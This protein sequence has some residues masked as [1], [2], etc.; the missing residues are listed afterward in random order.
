MHEIIHDALRLPNAALPHH[1]TAELARRWPD[2]VV[3]ESGDSD[4]DVEPFAQAGLCELVPSSETCLQRPLIWAGPDDGL[5]D[6]IDVGAFDI[7]WSGHAMPALKLTWPDG[8]CQASRWWLVAPDP[9]VGRSFFDAVARWNTEV[10]GEVLVFHAGHWFKDEGFFKAVRSA[11]FDDVV[12]APGLA[13]TVRLDFEQFFASSDMYARYRV[14]WKRGALF[15]GPP[16]NGKTH[17]VKAL[18]RSLGRPC[19][20]V[21]SFKAQ[22][23]SEH[24]NIRRV[25]QR[26][27]DAAP[28]ILVLEDLD[29]L[30]DDGNRAFFLNEVDGFAE[31]TGLVV[32]ATTNHPDRLDPAILDRP[33]RFDRKYHFGLPARPERLAFIAKWNARYAPEARL[34]D[35]GTERVADATEAFSFAYLKELFLSSLMRWMAAAEAGGMDGVMMREVESLER[36]RRGGVEAAP[37][38]VAVADDGPGWPPMPFPFG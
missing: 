22:Y 23:T 13:N 28:C 3:L 11:T 25:F 35:A 16:G 30:L 19:L 21:K 37:E 31:N 7:R 20:Y 4:C 27:R 14:P 32:L 36:Q 1:V 9:A 10:R 24:E 17:T 6:S 26:A 5:M 38:A 2:G 33:S 18:I 34:S 8:A 29:S 12:L 15:L